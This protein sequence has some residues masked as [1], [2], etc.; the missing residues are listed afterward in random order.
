MD[1]VNLTENHMAHVL[2]THFSYETKPQDQNYIRLV[3]PNS[4]QAFPL[5]II[6]TNT[7]NF[8]QAP[9]FSGLSS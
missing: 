5:S 9:P 7:W 8:V 3:P 4:T 1:P 2:S 6:K